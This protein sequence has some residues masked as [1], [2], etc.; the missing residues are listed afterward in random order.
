MGLTVF[1]AQDIPSIDAAML[2]EVLVFDKVFWSVITIIVAVIG[3]RVWSGTLDRLGEQ[4]A[5][6][7][8]LLKKVASLSRFAIYLTCTYLVVF[9][10]LAPRKESLLAFSAGFVFVLGLALKPLAESIIAGVI[11]LIDSPF[12]VGDRVEF[13][14]TYGEVTEIGLRVV[15]ITTLDDNLVSIPNNKFL[16]EV[17]SSGNAGALDMMIVVDFFIGMDE[18]HVLA[19]RIVYE[20]AMTS[21]FAYLSKPVKVH[22]HE[23]SSEHAYCTRIRAKLY[24]IDVRYETD[25]RT[26]I[27]ERVRPVFRKYG[28][29]PPYHDERTLGVLKKNFRVPELPA[30]EPEPS[31]IAAAVAGVSETGEAHKALAPAAADEGEKKG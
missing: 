28:I 26:D 12:Q 27:T 3:A 19:K 20:A 15:R 9:G 14:G 8:L 4:F 10:I 25:L 2:G 5:A 17:V 31:V 13:A 11:I 24:V 22:V 1:L 18:D 21:R 7:R 6:R 30:D 29:C 16:S 23:V